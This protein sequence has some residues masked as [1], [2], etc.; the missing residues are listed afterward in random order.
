M[1]N[2][3]IYKKIYGNVVTSNFTVLKN[4]LQKYTL[5]DSRKYTDL[6]EEIHT[7]PLY[8]QTTTMYK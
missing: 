6:Y 8:N 1:K 5:L 4:L 2:N 3:I 7:Q